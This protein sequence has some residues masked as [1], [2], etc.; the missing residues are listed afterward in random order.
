MK[1]VD[2]GELV[3]S[4]VIISLMTPGKTWE[5]INI[6]FRIYNPNNKRKKQ[7]IDELP[8]IPQV[9]DSGNLERFPLVT[10]RIELESNQSYVI[11]PFT[12]FKNQESPF[13][14]R[15]FS[16]NSCKLQEY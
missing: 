6:G 14:L 7:F 10:K 1:D 4:T 13:L 12:E 9:C 5:E 2:Q 8:E 3:T 16:E 11:I 15:I